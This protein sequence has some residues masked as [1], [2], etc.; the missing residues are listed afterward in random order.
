MPELALTILLRPFLCSIVWSILALELIFEWLIRP[1]K[2]F[3]LMRSDK[4]YAPSS[5]RYINGFHLVTESI[6]LALFIPEFDCLATKLCGKRISFSGVDAALSAIYGPTR[7]RA[8]LG[9]LCIGL[10]SLRIV[11]LVRHWKIMWINRT[12]HDNAVGIGGKPTFIEALQV[13]S[14]YGRSRMVRRKS[15][16]AVSFFLLSSHVA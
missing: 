6:A 1:S 2:Y 14:I 11:G 10:I 12:F 13:D 8:A 7:A 15:Q 4:V 5:A 9:R 16:G 3:Q